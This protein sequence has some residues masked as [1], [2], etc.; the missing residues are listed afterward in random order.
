[1]RI[2]FKYI[3]A[4]F[5]L[6]I[7]YSCSKEPDNNP[8]DPPDDGGGGNEISFIDTASIE[9]IAINLMQY[10]PTW[11]ELKRFTDNAQRLP[12]PNFAKRALAW[13]E[14]IQPS[15]GNYAREALDYYDNLYNTFKPNISP[16]LFTVLPPFVN[17][18][19][20]NPTYP[21]SGEIFDKKLRSCTVLF[22]REKSKGRLTTF[23]NFWPPT[24]EDP[25][26]TSETMFNQWFDEKYLPE[27]IAEAKASELMKAEYLIAW[28]LELELFVHN[29]G[30]VGNGGFLDN[31]SGEE[32]LAFANNFK[33]K[34]RD[35]VK[36]HYHGKLIAHLYQNYFQR[37]SLWENMTYEGFDEL[38]MAFFPTLDVQTT[39]MYMDAQIRHYTK[40]IQN[41]GNLPWV[42]SEISLFEKYFPDGNL[43]SIE[44]EI[45]E[46]VFT[47]L[48]NAPI[49]PA[50][51]SPA[52]G[53]ILTDEAKNYIIQYFNSH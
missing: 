42:A 37:D 12:Y 46:T 51:I 29:L 45:Y 3:F 40:I 7:F 22:L 8:I 36:K 18:D 17:D 35:E 38:H 53:L 25:N 49:P 27:K 43:R 16:A 9:A 28:P 13:G 19:G 34:I 52:A 1:M 39:E 15:D 20:S 50:G 5:F 11:D 6:V 23:V 2:N 4:F 21:L 24:I 44:K 10:I 31:K 48:E 14:S 30:G 41:S 32:V 26:F 33:N 47:K